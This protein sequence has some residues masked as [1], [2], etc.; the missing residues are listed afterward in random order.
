MY[1]VVSDLIIFINYMF[2]ILFAQSIIV[3]VEV[4]VNFKRA[5]ALKKLL[6]LFAFN[7]AFLSFGRF[8][9]SCSRA[10]NNYW[11]PFTNGRRCALLD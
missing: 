5:G 9:N 11:S 8:K 7:T 6:L 3:F 4:L 1:P 10:K 2:A